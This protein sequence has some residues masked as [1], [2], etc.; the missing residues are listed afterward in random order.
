MVSLAERILGKGARFVGSHPMAGSEQ[1]G[2]AAARADLLKGALCI[3][4]PTPRTP[5]ALTAKVERFWRALGMRTHRLPPAVHDKAVARISHLPHALSALLMMLPGQADLAI[6]ASGFSD[7]TRLAG[8]DVEMWRDIMLTNAKAI[9]G[10][11]DDF[12]EKLMHLRYLVELGYE[13]EIVRL[14]TAAKL[15]REK[16]L[17]ANNNANIVGRAGF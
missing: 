4:T 12:D 15:R 6:A 2:P 8:G 13:K 11:I 9:L 3:L 5:S 7:M 17:S 14:L 10:A 1:R 16:F